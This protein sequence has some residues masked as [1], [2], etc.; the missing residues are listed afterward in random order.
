MVNLSA[1]QIAEANHPLS[2]AEHVLTL[3]SQKLKFSQ[4]PLDQKIP[5]TGE[6]SWI[7]ESG[8]ITGIVVNYFSYVFPFWQ[9]VEKRLEPEYQQVSDD[10]SDA[11]PLVSKKQKVTSP[12]NFDSENGKYYFYEGARGIRSREIPEEQLV[13]TLCGGPQPHLGI[14][15]CHLNSI[16][17]QGIPDLLIG[18]KQKG[19]HGDFIHKNF[20]TRAIARLIGFDDRA[21]LVAFGRIQAAGL[22]DEDTKFQ[23]P[24]KPVITARRIDTAFH[25]LA[26]AGCFALL[27]AT[28][29]TSPGGRSFIAAIGTIT[30][31]A[32]AYSRYYR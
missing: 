13:A 26:A 30:G 21:R 25:S 4:F 1:Y 32:Y 10:F 19:E 3:G 6:R 22:L 29:Q 14:A 7:F 2:Y 20:I 5:L 27:A 11:V 24:A 12:F 8:R 31:M 15:M 9:T 28:Y 17:A 18:I 23:V 16:S